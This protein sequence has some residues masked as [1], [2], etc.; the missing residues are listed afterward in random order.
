MSKCLN[1]PPP[2]PQGNELLVYG[3]GAYS[4]PDGLNLAGNSRV[5]SIQHRGVDSATCA[6]GP[7]CSL[8]LD[9]GTATILQLARIK[10]FFFCSVPF[11]SLK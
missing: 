2:T 11:P 7:S 8:F 3:A 4:D 5:R 6:C 9:P 10:L 1:D